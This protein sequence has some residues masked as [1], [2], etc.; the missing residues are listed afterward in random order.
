MSAAGDANDGAEALVQNS[1]DGLAPKFRDA[2]EQSLADCDD[3]G[4]D[5][6][7]YESL[8]SD[9]LQKLYY[10]RGRVPVYDQEKI[11][12]NAKSALYGFHFFALAV[13]VI[14]KADRWEVS[15]DWRKQVSTIFK[16][17]ACNAGADWPHPDTPH[18]YWGKC[19]PS[20]SDEHRRIYAQEG[21]DALWDQLGA[22]E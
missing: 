15:D 9:E 22:Y 10:A 8:R 12:T 17:N 16:K 5:A 13:D 20:P 21:L 7:V 19:P 4:L 11:V 18:Y 6:Y 2:V 3:A 1:L 14:S